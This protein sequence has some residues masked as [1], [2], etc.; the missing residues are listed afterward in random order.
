MYRTYRHKSLKK[1]M[2]PVIR[3]CCRYRKNRLTVMAFL[4]KDTTVKMTSANAAKVAKKA[5]SEN[6]G[7]VSM[8]PDAVIKA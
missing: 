6:P 8:I 7:T 1:S 4:K 3:L 5:D 2:I